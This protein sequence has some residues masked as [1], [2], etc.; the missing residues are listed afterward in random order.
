HIEITLFSSATLFRSTARCCCLIIIIAYI[1]IPSIRRAFNTRFSAAYYQR[2]LAL[3]GEPHPGALGFRVAETPVFVP[4]ILTERLV[5][6][7][8]EHTSELQSRENL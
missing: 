3:L 5:E 4:R 6:R 7:S 2:L 8:E 1:M